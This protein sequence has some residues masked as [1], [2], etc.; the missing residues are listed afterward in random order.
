MYEPEISN[1]C[2]YGR[3][4]PKFAPNLNKLIHQEK[5]DLGVEGQI[6]DSKLMVN[7]VLMEDETKLLILDNIAIGTKE[8]PYFVVFLECY[9]IWLMRYHTV[10]VTKRKIEPRTVDP[11]HRRL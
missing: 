4:H 2:D 1:P 8:D 10:N 11:P 3:R 9:W 5:E 6:E 7:R